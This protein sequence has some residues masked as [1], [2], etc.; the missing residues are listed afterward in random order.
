[1]LNMIILIRINLRAHNRPT[2]QLYRDRLIR[3][4]RPQISMYPRIQDLAFALDSLALA[5]THR[6]TFVRLQMVEIEKAVGGPGI[7]FQ[8]D[9]CYGVGG[10]VVGEGDPVLVVGCG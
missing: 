5:P 6:D 4:Y 2:S 8:P 3:S 7:V 10:G 1:M 9:V